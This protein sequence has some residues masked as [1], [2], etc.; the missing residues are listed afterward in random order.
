MA[1]EDMQHPVRRIVFSQGRRLTWLATQLGISTNHLHRVLLPPDDP[2]SRTTPEWF[3][4]RVAV[5]LG[6]PE[7]MLKPEERDAVAA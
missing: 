5:L 6:V 2:H 1:L 7:D 4:P 3:Y